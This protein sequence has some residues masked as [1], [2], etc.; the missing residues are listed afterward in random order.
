MGASSS[1]AGQI[2]HLLSSA[3][4]RLDRPIVSVHGRGFGGADDPRHCE[5]VNKEG[6]W[7]DIVIGATG[8][9]WVGG[10]FTSSRKKNRAARNRAGSVFDRSLTDRRE[11]P[12]L[13]E[14]GARI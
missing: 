7:P 2:S 3:H 11:I 6:V 4:R 1:A 14:S 8:E 9:S 13:R 12:E 10:E 5:H